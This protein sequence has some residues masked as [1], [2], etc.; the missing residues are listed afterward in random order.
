MLEVC[1][2]KEGK[3]AGKVLQRLQVAVRQRLRLHGKQR[4]VTRCV[5]VRLNGFEDD[6]KIVGMVVDGG[7]RGNYFCQ[8]RVHTS[9]RP[10]QR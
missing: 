9:S 6:G 7:R 4:L 1:G 10:R 3:D 8:L 2:A 5:L